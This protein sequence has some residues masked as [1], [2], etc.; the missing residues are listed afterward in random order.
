MSTLADALP[1]EIERVQE[2]IPIYMSVPMGFIAAGMMKE[3]IRKAHAAM[4]AGDV[5]GMLRVYED[6][7]GYEA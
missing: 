5:V 1:K 2:L 7:K 4:M 3:S 6:L